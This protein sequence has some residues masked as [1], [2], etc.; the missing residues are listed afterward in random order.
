M[1]RLKLMLA[2]AAV[3]P[4]AALACERPPAAGR[5]PADEGSSRTSAPAAVQAGQAAGAVELGTELGPDG[6]VKGNGTDIK[7]GDPVF[8]QIQAGSLPA[9]ANVRLAWVGPQGATL[10][11]DEIVM[12]PDARAITLKARDTSGWAPG[13]YRVDVAV[14]GANIASK[15][16]RVLERGSA[17]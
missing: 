12:P 4:L 15:A 17:D 6:D 13:D 11:T 3:L 7:A 1:Q 5:G 8:A 16:F 10:G 2:A 9:G 14:G